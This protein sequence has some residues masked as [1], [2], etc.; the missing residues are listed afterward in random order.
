MPDRAPLLNIASLTQHQSLDIEDNT[1]AMQGN[2]RTQTT[3]WLSVAAVVVIGPFAINHLIAER[4][5]LGLF[6]LVVSGVLIANGLLMFL[7]GA[8]PRLLR[9]AVVPLCT[10][11]LVMAIDRQGIIGVLW[12]FPTILLFFATLEELS[13]IHI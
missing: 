2:F 10:V 8:S 9:L 7:Q 11:A 13:L 3:V 5:I 1:L 12:T 6:S 4:W